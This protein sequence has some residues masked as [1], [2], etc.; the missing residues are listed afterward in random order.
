[1]I[2]HVRPVV[3]QIHAKNAQINILMTKEHA[4]VYKINFIYNYWHFLLFFFKECHDRCQKCD[5]ENT[6]LIECPTS[7]CSKCDSNGVCLNCESGF[8]LL[9]ETKTC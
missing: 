2:S 1:M 3:T 8:K 9:F 5:S 6:C 4:K 7:N